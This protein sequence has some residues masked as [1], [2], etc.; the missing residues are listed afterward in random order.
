MFLVDWFWGIL[1]FL[2]LANRS[3]RIIFPWA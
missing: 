1:S 2:G 3:A